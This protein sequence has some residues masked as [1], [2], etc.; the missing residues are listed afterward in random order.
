LVDVEMEE[1]FY[2]KRLKLPKDAPK[3]AENTERELLV[4]VM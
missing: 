3:D 4:H 1:D 2:A